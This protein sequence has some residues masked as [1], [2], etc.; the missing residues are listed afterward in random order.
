MAI[1]E[2]NSTPVN[3]QH[4]Q[5]PFKVQCKRGRVLIFPAEG[6]TQ[7]AQVFA[8]YGIERG[9]ADARLFRAAAEMMALLEECDEYLSPNTQNYIG[10]ESILHS[11]MRDLISKVKGGTR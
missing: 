4:S 7:I 2:N 8:F 5:G 6:A 1:S 10:C 9:G 11:K 3:P